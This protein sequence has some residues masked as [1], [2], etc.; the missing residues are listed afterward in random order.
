MK[1]FDGRSCEVQSLNSSTEIVRS[2]RDS[3]NDSPDQ[4][5]QAY[6]NNS[7]L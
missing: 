6:I 5:Y 1:R 2:D 3:K 4:T 7:I